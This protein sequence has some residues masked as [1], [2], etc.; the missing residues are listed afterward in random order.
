[1]PDQNEEIIGSVNAQLMADRIKGL[2]SRVADLEVLTTALSGMERQVISNRCT[3]IVRFALN[4]FSDEISKGDLEKSAEMLKHV[5][6]MC[7]TFIQLGGKLLNSE[8]PLREAR[9]W[10]KTVREYLATLGLEGLIG[11][12]GIDRDGFP[13]WEEEDE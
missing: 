10:F 4:N 13:L 7:S 12:P 1:M 11:L 5:D 3:L 2:E 9:S 8:Y 6:F